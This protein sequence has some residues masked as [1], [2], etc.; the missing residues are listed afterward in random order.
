MELVRAAAVYARV[1]SDQTGQQ[2]AV[3]RQLEDCRKLAAERGWAVAEEYVDNDI[4]AFRGKHRPAYERMLADIAARV[5]DGVVVYNTDRLTRRPIELEEFTLVCE[6]A[7]VRSFATVTA[8]IDLGNDDGMFMA[9]VLAAVAAKESGRK[10][11][12]LRRKAQQNAEAG[13]PNGGHLRPFGY[14]SDRV[15]VNEAEAVLIREVVDRFLAGESLHSLAVWMESTGVPTTGGRPWH[16]S[17][18]RQMLISARIAGLRSHKSVVVGPAVWEPIIT[19][20]QREQVIAAVERKRVSGRRVPRRY[21]LSGLLRCGKCGSRLYSARRETTRRYVCSS[22]PDHRGCGKLTVVAEPVEEW[23]AAAALYRL[24][25][26]ELTDRV[27]GRTDADERLSTL[28]A[29]LQ[30]A[31]AK[32]E[33]LASMWAADEISRTEWSAARAPIEARIEQAEKELSRL[34]STDS[35]ATLVGRGKELEAE[36]EALTLARQ[37]AIIQAVL[38]YATILPGTPGTRTVDPSRIVPEWRD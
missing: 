13:R 30:A 22:G 17:T 10:S 25:T 7:G 21:L 2:L 33:E 31:Q 20:E 26:P 32:R 37:V 8:D 3:T 11:E 29:Q 18:L 34:R 14:E 5:R 24:D 36:W 16:T 35:L 12:R 6:A 1:S 9:R 27:A 23:L 4:S 15:T 38:D 28:T 19:P